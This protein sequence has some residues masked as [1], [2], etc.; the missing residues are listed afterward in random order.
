MMMN[1]IIIILVG[2]KYEFKS[3]IEKKQSY[4]GNYFLIF[5]TR[6]G[7]NIQ[8]DINFPTFKA[9]LKKHILAMCSIEVFINCQR[10]YIYILNVCSGYYLI[11]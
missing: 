9:T 7:I 11:A 2:K 3:P 10:V 1:L 4:I 8:R 6:V 5:F